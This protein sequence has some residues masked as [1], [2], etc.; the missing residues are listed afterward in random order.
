MSVY[1]SL[2]SVIQELRNNSPNFRITTQRKIIIKAILSMK[3]HFSADEV[4]GEIFRLYPDLVGISKATVYNTLD[5]LVKNRILTNIQAKTFKDE[6]NGGFYARNYYDRRL[7]AHINMVC[8]MC[9]KI[10]DLDEIP[11]GNI[12]KEIT[13][14]SSW[15]LIQETIG[16]HGICQACKAG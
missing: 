11:L 13:T 15:D 12:I 1:N 16:L 7:D 8:T 2:D 3:G 6:L 14:N 9:G 5:I 4:L 10:E